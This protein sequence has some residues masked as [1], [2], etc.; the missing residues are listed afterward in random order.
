MERWERIKYLPQRGM[1]KDG[2]RLTASKEHIGFSRYAA[3]EGMVLL[4]NNG[5]LPLQ[6]GTSVAIFGK[7]QIDYIKGGGGSGDVY[8]DYVRNVY[9]GM[10]IKE[11]EEKVKIYHDL[12]R[13]YEKYISET[14]QVKPEILVPEAEITAAQVRKARE[15]AQVAIITICRHSGEGYDRTEA[16]FYLTDKEKAMVDAVCGEFDKVVVVLNVGGVVDSEWFKDNDK[17]SAVLLS[18]NGGMEGGLAIA[19]IL[20]GDANPS[21]KLT[22]TFAKSFGDYPSSDTFNE[23][24]VYVKYYEDIYVG[25]RYFETIP[26]AYKKV[27]YPFGYGMSYTDFEISNIIAQEKD[28]KI[29]VNADVKNIGKLSGK[30]VVEVYYSAPQ[31]LLG[32]PARELG[33]F[34]KTRLLAPDESETLT[35]ELP[36]SLMASFDDLGKVTK[37]AYILE[38]G[39]YLFYVGTSVRDTVLADYCYVLDENVVVEQLKEMLAPDRLEKRMLADGTFESL[40]VTMPKTPDYY[41][42]PKSDLYN[43]DEKARAITFDM[44]A[45]GKATLDEFLDR[46]DTIELLKYTGGKP[47]RGV[48]LTAGIGGEVNEETGVDECGVPCLMTT[49]G[50]AGVRAGKI[51][52][53]VHTTAFPCATLLA[54]TWDPEILYLKGKIGATE[55]EENNMSIWLTPGM[56]IHRNPLCGRNFEY[57]SEDP[58]ISGVMAAAEVMGI[59]SMNVSACPK[60]FACNNKETSRCFCNALVSQRALRE[61]Y[62][63]GFE[64][65]VKTARPWLIMTSYNLING[66]RAGESEELL[67][68]ILR[69]EWGYD[70]LVTTDWGAYSTQRCELMAG[71]DIKMFEGNNPIWTAYG[72]FDVS[73]MA[74]K[75]VKRLLEFILRFK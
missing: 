3:T 22:D 27:N 30:E 40:P 39:E 57:F 61:I 4:K 59:Q 70:G 49:D 62:L 65:C 33:A 36:I 16:D 26:E 53:R 44:V 55:T 12:S 11:G 74:R 41:K 72:E 8:C 13:Y 18:W 24:E 28:G 43:G 25:Y 51:G 66:F 37:S 69:G 20:V 73:P 38:K 32:K 56:N 7:A 14:P 35:M 71:N 34:K 2:A 5:T 42:I 50:P 1:G 48:S 52:N 10:K 17:I 67:S 31:G 9:E 29:I 15:N 64:I 75:S 60:H 19:D 23:S 68:G 46:F 58:V 54:C 47:D 45:E 6:N 21:G 63:K